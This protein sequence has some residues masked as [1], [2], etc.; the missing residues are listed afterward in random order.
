MKSLQAYLLAGG[1][2]SRMGTDKALITIG[3]LTLLQRQFA[4]LQ[5]VSSSP[6]VIAPE[7]RYAS[8]GFPVIPDLE[9]GCGPLGGI[10]TALQHA[11]SS[12]VLILG[13][14]LP[15]VNEGLLRWLLSAWEDHFTALIPRWQGH[16]Q[17]L[18]GLYSGSLLPLMHSLLAA[19]NYRLLFSLDA[20]GASYM[21]V[22]EAEWNHPL[23]LAN[24]NTP[25]E[26]EHFR[27][28]MP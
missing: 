27:N 10:A 1:Q 28:F 4:L 2:S 15:G 24:V 19:R 13:V 14:D 26:W 20:A 9:P 7:G 17:P 16:A 21:D 22:P 23:L 12:P 25:E 18:C 6:V 11:S 8:F 3:G 5:S